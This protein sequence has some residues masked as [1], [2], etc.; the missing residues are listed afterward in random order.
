MLFISG[1]NSLV[2]KFPIYKDSLNL[3]S[4]LSVTSNKVGPLNIRC[5]NSTVS[6]ACIFIGKGL[7]ISSFPF[8]VNNGILI[9]VGHNEFK[10]LGASSI[11]KLGKVEHVLFDLKYVLDKSDVDIRL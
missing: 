4:S 8:Q 6:F 5:S 11:R 3:V 2:I 7:W 9:A 1:I 10:A